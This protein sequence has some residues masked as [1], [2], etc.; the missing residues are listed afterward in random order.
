[1]EISNKS[2]PPPWFTCHSKHFIMVGND[3]TKKIEIKARKNGGGWKGVQKK[4][5]TLSETGT[6]SQEMKKNLGNLQSY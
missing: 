3:R 5:S 4:F 6:Y 1:M 2:K